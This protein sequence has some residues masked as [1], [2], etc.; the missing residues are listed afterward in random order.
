MT[1]S[2]RARNGLIAAIAGLVIGVGGSILMIV[3]S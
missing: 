1:M 3:L 2:T